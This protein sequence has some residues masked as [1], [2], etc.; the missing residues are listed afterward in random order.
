MKRKYRCCSSASCQRA[1]P[2]RVSIPASCRVLQTS[3]KCRKA[4]TLSL[5]P[6]D[7]GC[8]KNRVAMRRASQSGD[9][10]GTLPVSQRCCPPCLQSGPNGGSKSNATIW[11]MGTVEG[12]KWTHFQHWARA[13]R[14]HLRSTCRAN[15]WHMCEIATMSRKN[16]VDEGNDLCAGLPNTVNREPAKASAATTR[17]IRRASLPRSRVVVVCLDPLPG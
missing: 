12:F 15:N 16:G 1:S 13:C 4:R 8:W 6:V 3:P 11:G 5:L 10:R 14:H 9:R 17:N 2:F 7:W